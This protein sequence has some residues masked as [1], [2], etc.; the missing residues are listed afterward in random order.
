MVRLDFDRLLMVAIERRFESRLMA[1]ARRRTHLP[2]TTWKLRGNRRRCP[3]IR[4]WRPT[5]VTKVFMHLAWKY[6]N[7]RQGRLFFGI[8]A[9]S[10]IVPVE[11][12]EDAMG[13]QT[14]QRECR[15]VDQKTIV[16]TASDGHLRPCWWGQQQLNVNPARTS[17]P[18]VEYICSSWI[19]ATPTRGKQQVPAKTIRAFLPCASRVCVL[20]CSNT[21]L[22][23]ALFQPVVSDSKIGNHVCTMRCCQ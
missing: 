18:P 10:V 20:V 1:P 13:C 4:D 8:Q 9:T 15:R 21:L 6:T 22:L 11:L 19:C 5:A 3:G 7:Q 12:L 23:G 14:L 16:I 2:R 17:S